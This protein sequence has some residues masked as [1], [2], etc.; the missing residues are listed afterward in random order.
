MFLYNPKATWYQ[1]IQL[2]AVVSSLFETVSRH[3]NK[4]V[5]LYITKQ[6]QIHVCNHTVNTLCFTCK[7]ARNCFSP[8]NVVLNDRSNFSMMRFR[9]RSR[10]RSPRGPKATTLRNAVDVRTSKESK[11]PSRTNTSQ[12]IPLY[13]DRMP[14]LGFDL[15]FVPACILL[16]GGLT[17]QNCGAP[18]LKFDERSILPPG[19][20]RTTGACSG[21]STLMRVTRPLMS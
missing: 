14:A 18:S 19:I 15:H 13:C 5:H 8:E 1:W 16:S 21:W 7:T 20:L 11:H 12:N 10:P 17:Q 2:T 4:Y 9:I 3:K 6:Q